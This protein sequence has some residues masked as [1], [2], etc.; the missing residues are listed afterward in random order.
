MERLKI[1]FIDFWPDFDKQ[2]NYF[3]RLLS[4]KYQLEI[5]EEPELIF[6][7]CFGSQYLQYTCLRIFYTGE[8]FRPDFT[9]C[10]Y[11]LS[12]VRSSNRRHFRLPFYKFSINSDYAHKPLHKNLNELTTPRSVEELAAVWT[13]KKKFCCMVVSNPY[14]PQRLDFFNKLSKYQQIDSGGIVLNNVGGPVMDKMAFIR[15]YRFVIAFENESEPSYTTEKLIEPMMADC[16]PIYWGDPLVGKDFNKKRFVDRADFRST[17]ALI[18]R[19]LAIDQNPEQAV[20]ILAQPVFPNNQAPDCVDDHK[21]LAFL[22][23]IIAKRKQT[24]PVAQTYKRHLHRLSRFTGFYIRIAKDIY[25]K[26]I[27]A[28]L[29]F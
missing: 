5:C 24:T 22:Q 18:E 15:E 11:A 10:D 27:Q 6:Y 25:Q 21:I 8:N 4:T 23:A 16:I 12:F 7:S 14:A 13:N 17:E 20:A 26:Q 2:D 19:I 29:P 9:G 28:R 1:N 3:F